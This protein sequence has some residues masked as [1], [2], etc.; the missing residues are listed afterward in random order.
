MD[1][2]LK[3]EQD[4]SKSKDYMYSVQDLI[5]EFKTFFFAGT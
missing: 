2:K 5:D 3:K 1:G 4:G